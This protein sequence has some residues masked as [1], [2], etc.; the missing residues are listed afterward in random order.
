[1][2]KVYFGEMQNSIYNTSLYFDNSYEDE[3]II[4]PMAKRIIKDIDN[5]NE[6]I[7][8]NK[9]TSFNDG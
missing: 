7:R 8:R 3:W 4:S 2:L 1:M 5:S 6:F 9:N